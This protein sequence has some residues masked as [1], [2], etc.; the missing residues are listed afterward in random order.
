MVIPVVVR[1]G[2][3]CIVTQHI[4]VTTMYVRPFQKSWLTGMTVNVYVI[5]GIWLLE[6]DIKVQFKKKS[7]KRSGHC[8]YKG[9]QN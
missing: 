2:F 9:G 7:T 6:L 3:E 5:Q 8:N 1:Y 4:T